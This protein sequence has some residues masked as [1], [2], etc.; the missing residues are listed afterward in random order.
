METFVIQLVVKLTMAVMYK[1]AFQSKRRPTQPSMPLR[2]VDNVV[3]EDQLLLGKQRQL[4]FI[5]F[6]DECVVG[7]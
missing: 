6:T 2:A 4:L 3:D 5:S 7:R 1:I